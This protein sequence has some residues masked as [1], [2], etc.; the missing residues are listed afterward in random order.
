M[1]EALRQSHSKIEI[2]DRTAIRAGEWFVC[3]RDEQEKAKSKAL[4]FA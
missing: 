1:R 2:E 3:V 4:A